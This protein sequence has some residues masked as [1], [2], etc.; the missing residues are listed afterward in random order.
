M[1]TST[2][3]LA[4]TDCSKFLDEALDDNQGARIFIGSYGQ[5]NY[6]ATR[7]NT[8]RRIT[9]DDN[10]AMYPD[11]SLPLHGRCEYDTLSIRLREDSEGNWWVYAVKVILNMDN[12][13]RL[14]EIDD[15]PQLEEVKL[16]SLQP[17]GS[18]NGD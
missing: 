8:F 5:A 4:Y 11:P 10:R 14:S 2:S 16:I 1:P 12:V 9:R 3:R 13:E 17:E 7:L 6:F 15:T 18:S